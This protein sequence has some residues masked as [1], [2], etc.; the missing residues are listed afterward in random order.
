[1][2]NNLSIRH[3]FLLPLSPHFIGI[4]FPMIVLVKLHYFLWFGIK[5]IH[6]FSLGPPHFSCL[7]CNPFV[8]GKRMFTT[9]KVAFWSRLRYKVELS[10]S[11][12]MMVYEKIFRDFLI[13][14]PFDILLQLFMMFSLKKLH[15]VMLSPALLFPPLD[16]QY[17]PTAVCQCWDCRPGDQ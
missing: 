17:F 6:G 15:S 5:S 7:Q 13:G 2:F 12:G 10:F 1:M 14:F 4:V 3:M 8:P 11:A 16:N 9:R